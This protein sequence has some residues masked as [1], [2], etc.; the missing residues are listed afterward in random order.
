MQKH[1]RKY[2]RMLSHVDISLH[3]EPLTFM[4][5]VLRD[6]PLRRLRAVVRFLGQLA[7]T[8]PSR[9]MC[10]FKQV[11]DSHALFMIYLTTGICSREVFR[12]N[13][14]RVGRRRIRGAR[15]SPFGCYSSI[16][17]T[18]ICTYPHRAG[19]TPY[20]CCQNSSFSGPI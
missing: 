4:T 20:M 19:G 15:G 2:F 17:L 13:A 1:R 16:H 10:H 12:E 18:F 7:F 6:V 8:S 9:T 3:R 5:W 11:V 14:R